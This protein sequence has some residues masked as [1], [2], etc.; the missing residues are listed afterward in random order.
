M[1]GFQLKAMQ[2]F[3]LLVI[4]IVK[5]HF[6][7][8]GCHKHITFDMNAAAFELHGPVPFLLPPPSYP[9]K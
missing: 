8:R 1:P 7:K 6:D 9:D 5:L 2:S 3:Y 4:G